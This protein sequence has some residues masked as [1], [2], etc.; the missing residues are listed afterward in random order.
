MSN[1]YGVI[2]APV[3]LR[4]DIYSVLGLSPYQGGYSLV[5]AAGNT[6]GKINKWA[7]FKPVPLARI[8]AH[9][10]D[11]VTILNPFTSTAM[12]ADACIGTPKSVIETVGGYQ[13]NMFVFFGLG[14]PMF[15]GQD[16]NPS[17]RKQ[18]IQLMAQDP[19]KYNWPYI[20]PSGDSSEPLRQTDFNGYD[21]AVQAPINYYAT[22]TYSQTPGLVSVQT[23]PE[24]ESQI[25]METLQ[26]FLG[27]MTM[28]VKADIWVKGENSFYE[29]VE[30]GE[31]GSGV[32][33]TA[34]IGPYTVS[35]DRDMEAY[36]FAQGSY[37]GNVWTM[38]FPSLPGSPNPVPFT[39]HKSSGEPQEV[40][41]MSMDIW[42]AGNGFA[43]THSSAFFESFYNVGEGSYSL[44]CTSSYYCIRA[45]LTNTTDKAVTID[46]G[47]ITL[48]WW[49]S[50]QEMTT[51]FYVGG[52]Q[53]TKFTVPANGSVK[54]DIEIPYLFDGM[55]AV[56]GEDYG[57]IDNMEV[58][59]KG[60]SATSFPCQVRK[61]ASADQHNGWFYSQNEN[62]Y[63]QT[64]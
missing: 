64:R 33:T 7:K 32:D 1:S 38:L 61:V 47:A 46:T 53:V 14:V 18:Y 6:H 26:S 34:T 43:W 20:P 17:Y 55:D 44:L 22:D 11:K 27:A 51:R 41:I 12:T 31:L 56:D 60:L 59:Y 63:Y 37:G 19:G 9:L 39:A 3:D 54:L 57:N 58:L 50:G 36:I 62:R 21:H 2:K 30:I 52:N 28:T 15:V 23:M 29:T 42:S 10:T 35:S 13:V 49:E 4:R 16:A 8:F 48:K 45:T 25:S 5:Y 24:A 40:I